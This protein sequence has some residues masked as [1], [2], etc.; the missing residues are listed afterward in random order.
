MEKNQTDP[1]VVRFIVVELPGIGRNKLRYGA[2]N[3]EK[4]SS[5]KPKFF[6]SGE[7]KPFTARYY[8]RFEDTPESLRADQE[9]TGCVPTNASAWAAGQEF[10]EKLPNGGGAD[11]HRSARTRRIL[12]IAQETKQLASAFDYRGVDL[13]TVAPVPPV[14]SNAGKYPV[15]QDPAWPQFVADIRQTLLHELIDVTAEAAVVDFFDRAMVDKDPNDITDNMGVLIDVAKVIRN[16]YLPRMKDPTFFSVSD[17]PVCQEEAMLYLWF[18]TQCIMDQHAYRHAS[19]RDPQ[20]SA[21][22][23]DNIEALAA[24][25]VSSIGLHRCGTS[26]LVPLVNFLRERYKKNVWS[27]DD[28]QDMLREMYKRLEDPQRRKEMMQYNDDGFV[29][30]GFDP[31]VFLETALAYLIDRHI[32][33]MRT[34]AEHKKFREDI[35]GPGTLPAFGSWFDDVAYEHLECLIEKEF[36]QH[37][38]WTP[39]DTLQRQFVLHY[40]N[41]EQI[42]AATDNIIELLDQKIPP[43]VGASG[44]VVDGD[45]DIFGSGAALRVFQSYARRTYLEEKYKYVGPQTLGVQTGKDMFG[46]PKF[47]QTTSA[48]SKPAAALGPLAPLQLDYFHRIALLDV[49]AS[50]DKQSGPLII[51]WL[52]VPY[53]PLRIGIDVTVPRL[54]DQMLVQWNVNGTYIDHAEDI[55]PADRIAVPETQVLSKRFSIQLSEE[56]KP[57]DQTIQLGARNATITILVSAKFTTYGRYEIEWPAVASKT[58]FV[59]PCLKGLCGFQKTFYLRPAPA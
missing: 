57:R 59:K 39:G 15:L 11:Y 32:A 31:D 14:V 45:N 41:R 33:T 19:P 30:G 29:G 3:H 9:V 18:L 51:P 1:N 12:E 34:H 21:Y 35:E 55:T 40:S 4:L 5:P 50:Q 27:A 46:Y 7:V 47:D 44:L 23:Q 17:V 38:E 58:I 43:N 48:E 2:A 24:F 42:P 6:Q 53:Y 56:F 25:F 22:V 52:P 36:L 20:H 8:L 28:V 54:A 37:D 10:L 16:T 26:V 49:F 13:K